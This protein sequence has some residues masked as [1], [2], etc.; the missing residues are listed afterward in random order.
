MKLQLADRNIQRPIGLLER[1]LVTTYGIEYE[2]TFAVVDFGQ[3][4]NYDVILGRPFMRQLKMIQ[5]WG[6]KYIYLWQDTLITRVN[7]RDHS[8]RD[9]VKTPVEDFEFA[10]ISYSKPSWIGKPTHL[11]M[12][13]TS[14]NRDQKERERKE[15]ELN[16]YILKPFLEHKFEPLGWNDVLAIVTICVN[17]VTPTLFCDEDGFDVIPIQMVNVINIQ[18]ENIPN[19][20]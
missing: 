15:S 6:F 12:C 14:K 4:P 5:D 3:N 7:M 11:W 10:T 16:Y 13:G 18:G 9:V 20:F 2:H 1:V 19:N 8:F 17:D